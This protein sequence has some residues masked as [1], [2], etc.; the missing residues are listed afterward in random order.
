MSKSD[1]FGGMTSGFVFPV[2]L[3][4]SGGI[5]VQNQNMSTGMFLPHFIL[6]EIPAYCNFDWRLKLVEANKKLFLL[7]QSKETSVMYIC[8][9]R[10]MFG[11]LIIYQSF[12][13]GFLLQ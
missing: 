3:S 11:N 6:F 5:K 13:S 2:V 8:F 4:A 1:G 9:C 12:F 10:F 7:Q